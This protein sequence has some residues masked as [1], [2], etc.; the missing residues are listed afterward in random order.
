MGD[1]IFRAG[2]FDA[3]LMIPLPLFEHRQRKRGFNQSMLLCE[4]MS[5][6]LKIPAAEHSIVRPLH[7]ATQT[8]KGRMERWKNIE[9]KFELR[10]REL[11]T[12]K[13]ILLVDDVI[14]TG[15]TLESCGTEILKAPNASLS[16]ACLCHAF[17]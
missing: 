5:E 16:I 12:G 7:T 3:D 10:D 8:N 14:T 4:G 11:V 6:L 2:R 9:G 15:A 1:T 13:H 17:R